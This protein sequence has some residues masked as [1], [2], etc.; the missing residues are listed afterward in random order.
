MLLVG[1]CVEATPA[2][3]YARYLA[4][5]QDPGLREPAAC[6]GLAGSVGGDCELTIAG[7]RLDAGG[8]AEAVCG[9]VRAG[10]WRS[11][12]WFLAAEAAGAAG[13]DGYAAQLCRRS[14]PFAE[15][16]AQH[17]WQ[18]AL[19]RQMHG[20][21][22][23]LPEAVAVASRTHDRWATK[24]AWTGDFSGRFWGL[25]FELAFSGQP[26][27]P[28]RCDGL[29]PERRGQCARA[30]EALLSRELAPALERAGVELCALPPGAAAV[31]PWLPLVPDPR[32]DAVVEQR[33]MARCP[34]P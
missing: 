29:A 33:R 6:A 13:R 11:E 1:A 12:C 21:A 24:L 14:G 15:D 23:A 3:T 8:A 7:R 17:L 19:H 20:R 22:D 27:D 4:V 31:A 9:D 2:P 34:P 18:G 30:A 26:I 16:C 28:G 25:G 32:L 5:V 10:V